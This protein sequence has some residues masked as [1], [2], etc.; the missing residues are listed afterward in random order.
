MTINKEKHKHS[1]ILRSHVILLRSTFYFS[2]F[3]FCYLHVAE[4]VSLLEKRWSN[5]K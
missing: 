2:P 5:K 1:G 4:N 3:L